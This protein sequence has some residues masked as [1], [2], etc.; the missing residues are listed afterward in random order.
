MT[1]NIQENLYNF[2]V[3]NNPMDPHNHSHSVLTNSD[4][5]Q[6]HRYNKWQSEPSYH[7]KDS[8]LTDGIIQDGLNFIQ[9]YNNT[10]LPQPISSTPIGE[11]WIYGPP[12]YTYYTQVF[13]PTSC[14][15][16]THPLFHN[17]LSQFISNV[18]GFQ[19]SHL[20]YITILTG[21]HYIWYNENPLN[22]PQKPTF[23]CFQLWGHPNYLPY[24][25]F[26]L[27]SHIKNINQSFL[28]K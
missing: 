8:Q 20:K 23:G 28:K 2:E 7:N 1:Y 26:L 24:A 3:L 19:G 27:T 14:F 21:C 5:E 22:L 9:E 25:T 17:I 12:I 16:T 13:L 18:I 15:N 11:P 10:F 6:Q 4:Y